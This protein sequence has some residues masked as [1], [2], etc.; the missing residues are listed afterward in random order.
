M[1]LHGDRIDEVRFPPGL[2][3][4]DIQFFRFAIFSNKCCYF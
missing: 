1:F 3:R 4:L 2:A